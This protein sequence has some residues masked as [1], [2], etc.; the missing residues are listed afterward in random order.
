MLPMFTD[1]IILSIVEQRTSTE[2]ILNSSVRL[3]KFQEIRW[4]Q[5]STLSVYTGNYVAEKKHVSLTI[6]GKQ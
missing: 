2:R 3:L 1:V 4:I 5:K 6:F